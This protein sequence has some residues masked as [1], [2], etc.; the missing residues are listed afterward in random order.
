[1]AEVI[2]CEY[3]GVNLFYENVQDER[4]ANHKDMP[5]NG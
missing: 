5:E 1:M 4:Y 3:C 2:F